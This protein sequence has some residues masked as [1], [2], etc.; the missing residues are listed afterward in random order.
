MTSRGRFVVL[1]GLDG[2]GTTTQAALLAKALRRAGHPVLLTREPSAGPVGVL[3][4]QELGR[5][6]LSNAALALLF[7]AD[8]LDHLASTVESGLD[9]GAVVVS[10]RYVLSSF[11]YQGR[12]LGQHW[13]EL[14]NSQARPPDLT[15]FLDVRP[16]VAALRRRLRG[17]RP[18]RFEDV[19]TQA[20][21]ARAYKVAIA[22]HGRVQHVRRLDGELDVQAVAA[23]VQAAVALMLGRTRRTKRRVG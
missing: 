4:R 23:Q 17:G 7:A 16:S 10:D 12:E 1:E 20:A 8:R 2:A 14:L 5:A 22:R 18:E 9:R 13:V 11:A 6:R 19:R 3:I 21:V 15:L